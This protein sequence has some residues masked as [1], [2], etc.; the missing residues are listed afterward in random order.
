M[1]S[2]SVTCGVVINSIE[3]YIHQDKLMVPQHVD[4]MY[5]PGGRGQHQ[6]SAHGEV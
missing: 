2:G 3:G 1:S 6:G 5:L 4:F